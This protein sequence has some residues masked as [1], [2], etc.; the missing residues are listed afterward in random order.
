MERQFRINW[1]ALVSEAK[2]RRKSQNLTQARLAKLA[3]VSTPTISRFESG[4]I[5]IQLPTVFNIFEVLGML[6]KRSLTFP[7][8]KVFYDS[9]RMVIK[10]VGQDS[11][12]VIQCAISREALEDHFKLATQSELKVFADNQARIE[13]E[14]RRK[15]LLGQIESDGTVL[16]CSDDLV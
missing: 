3:G 12:K 15:Y 16:V 1:Q 10:F 13:H 6:D 7:E 5:D 14:A 9:G 11:N 8:P 4:Q 2:L